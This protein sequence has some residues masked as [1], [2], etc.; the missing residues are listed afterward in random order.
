MDYINNIVED[1]PELIRQNTAKTYL[2]ENNRK[3]NDNDKGSYVE[4]NSMT[5]TNLQKKAIL[6]GLNKISDNE[7]I[8]DEKIKQKEINF[9]DL[10]DKDEKDNIDDQIE[11]ELGID[12]TEAIATPIMTKPK[13]TNS[14]YY[15]GL[16]K[17]ET[18]FKIPKAIPSS[19]KLII[20][21]EDK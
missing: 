14:E 2:K 15:T 17:F 9:H 11:Q 3:F 21:E 13:F 6:I 10:E 18:D 4:P 1:I 20:I 8:S 12:N 5:L 16:H 7:N 19:D